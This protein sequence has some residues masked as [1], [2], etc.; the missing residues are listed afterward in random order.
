MNPPITSPA[1]GRHLLWIDCSA[2][3]L[4]GIT[5]LLFHGWLSDLFQLPVRL[6][7]VMGVANLVYASYSFSLALRQKR[8][9]MLIKLLVLANFTW[10]ALCFIWFATFFTTASVFGLAQLGLE[11]LFVGGLALQEWRQRDALSSEV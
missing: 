2:G 3:A 5:V 1:G 4:V 11:G 7:F 10:A 9:L 8:P 6:V